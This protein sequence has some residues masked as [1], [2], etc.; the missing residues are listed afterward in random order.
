MGRATFFIWHRRAGQRC[1][2][3]LE[4]LED[5]TSIINVVV[6]PKVMEQ[7]RKEVLGGRA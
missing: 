3:L 1:L 2:R 5:E 4:A 6:W 7:Y